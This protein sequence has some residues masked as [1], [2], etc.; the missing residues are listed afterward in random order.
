MEVKFCRRVELTTSVVPNVG[1]RGEAQNSVPP[2]SLHD[3][4]RESFTL[5]VNGF[6]PLTVNDETLYNKFFYIN[7]QNV[8]LMKDTWTSYNF[9]T[10]LQN[11]LPATAVILKACLMMTC[12]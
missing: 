1:V 5:Y 4:L 2:L 7:I 3:L 8:F 9:N 10:N 11:Q 12:N 6:N